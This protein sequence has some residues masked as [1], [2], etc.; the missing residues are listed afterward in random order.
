MRSRRWL[1][2]RG[3]GSSRHVMDREMNINAFAG[4]LSRRTR[5]SGDSRLHG[6]TRAELQGV[7][8]HGVTWNGDKLNMR[9]IGFILEFWCL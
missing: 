9:L 7:I 2:H 1:S 5:R 3:P 4:A 8:A 6:I